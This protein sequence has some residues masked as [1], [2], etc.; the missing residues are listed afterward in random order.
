MSKFVLHSWR[1][2]KTKPH[3]P[4]ATGVFLVMRGRGEELDEMRKRTAFVASRLES[5][6]RANW[7]D[8]VVRIVER[9]DISGRECKLLWTVD[10]LN[11]CSRRE[12]LDDDAP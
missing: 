1:K 7:P 8:H 11:G 4:T 2:R 6:L 5:D 9:W 10:T 12:R 3:K